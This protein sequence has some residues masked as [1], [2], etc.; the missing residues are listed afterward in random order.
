MRQNGFTLIEVIIALSIFS[1]VLSLGYG[2]L[3][4]V[5]RFNE[6][7]E[8]YFQVIHAMQNEHFKWRNDEILENKTTFINQVAVI[9]NV[10]QY[11]LTPHI[12]RAEIT[13]N[14]R[15]GKKEYQVEWYLDR[16]LP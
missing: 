13:Y 15:V 9:Q 11:A 1:L 14:W 6:E 5:E 16:F 12:E 4:T 3:L 10:Y 7:N 2:M 8:I